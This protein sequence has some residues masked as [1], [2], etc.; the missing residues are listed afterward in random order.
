MKIG[1]RTMIFGLVLDAVGVEIVLGAG[2]APAA[3]IALGGHD[4]RM[5]AGVRVVPALLGAL[6]AIVAA[7][8]APGPAE[9]V[10]GVDLE[11]G[12]FLLELLLR[13]LA[14]HAA[15]IGDLDRLL[16][17]LHPFRHHGLDI[18]Q[19]PTGFTN[20]RCDL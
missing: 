9:A 14:A 11:R 5:R 7:H 4:H 2:N 20:T 17:A 12:G 8:H 19:V 3:P 15:V 6:P 1:A 16:A 18:A 13:E 10:C